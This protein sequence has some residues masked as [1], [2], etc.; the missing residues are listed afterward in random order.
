MHRDIKPGNI[1]AAQRGGVYDVAKLLDFGLVKSIV[2]GND[3]AQLTQDGTIIGSPQY[4]PPNKRSAI[5]G[6]DARSDIYSLGAMAY[7][8]L[9]GQ[10][11]FPGENT[12]KVLFAHVNEEPA[13]PPKINV[14]VPTDLEA[15]VMKSL[16]KDPARRYA[17]VVDL[18]DAGR[19]LLPR[20]LDKSD[21]RE[22]VD[23]RE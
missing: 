5:E 16:E 17:D 3:S 4:T 15:V 22:V 23:R 1:F 21:G 9:T 7:Y 8:L 6:P 11:V 19:V 2:A 10:P 20:L 18:E 12:L 13:V 14:E